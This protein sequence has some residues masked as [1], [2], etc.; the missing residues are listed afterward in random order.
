MEVV[1]KRKS[2][3]HALNV[4][5]L[6]PI[7]IYPSRESNKYII[8]YETKKY[9]IHSTLF[10]ISKDLISKAQGM[11]DFHTGLDI[12]VREDYRYSIKANNKANNPNWNI[13][14]KNVTI[15]IIPTRYPNLS[16]L[17][18]TLYYFEWRRTNAGGR[19]FI[20][21]SIPECPLISNG[22]TVTGVC[23]KLLTSQTSGGGTHGLHGYLILSPQ[24]GEFVIGKH[25]K[26]TNIN[27]RGHQ[28]MYI[29]SVSVIL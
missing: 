26:V 27:N 17:Y 5:L 3:L 2:I 6:N 16:P 8:G 19:D 21:F 10:K 1:N 22:N 7:Q 11:I 28:H 18:A 12:N 23:Y 4:F 9:R 15:R 14:A 24:H 29:N 13:K 20:E 25:V